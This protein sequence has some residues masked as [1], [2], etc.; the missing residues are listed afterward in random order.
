MNLNQTIIA[1][2]TES[3][4]FA[5]PDAKSGSLLRKHLTDEVWHAL[6]DVQTNSGATVLDCIRS[7]LA[8]SD[9]AIGVYACDAESLRCFGLLFD[10]LIHDL[11][12]SYN[13][14]D[15]P[16]RKHL[17][18]A[19]AFFNPDPHGI[20][21][22]STR[23]RIAR[24]IRGYRLMP[25]IHFDELIK[26]Q[27][28]L[29]KAFES[30]E[31]SLAGTYRLF[32]DK[33]MDSRRP[34]TQGSI[35]FGEIDRFQQAA[36][37]CRFW[38]DG[39]G[40]FTN[41]TGTLEVWVN[42]E[43]HLRIISIQQGGNIQVAYMGAL[44]ASSELERSLHF[45]H[46]DRYGYLASCPSNLGTGLR[47]SFHI[48]LPLTGGSVAFKNICATYGIA[49]RSASGELGSQL[50]P[51]YDISNRDRMRFTTAHCIYNLL[52]GTLKLIELEKSE[53]A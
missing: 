31:G 40:I 21:I 10:P 1:R 20:Y 12:G 42:E 37:I 29:Y 11:H 14:P 41:H 33:H 53:A 38:P 50:G 45:E 18:A 47:A 19:S 2:D 26:I 52:A 9:S 32:S 7:G 6:K 25:T 3:A 34:D 35:G 13:A 16:E 8:H 27:Q 46:S 5:W 51:I 48:H 49:V 17:E 44:H 39:R 22:R 43:D 23:I 30:F 36:G 4:A 28:L 15:R 24:N